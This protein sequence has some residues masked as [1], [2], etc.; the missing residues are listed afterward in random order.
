MP[1]GGKI[2]L[3][4]R[5]IWLERY[6]QGKPIASIAKEE[7]RTERTVID[8]L[9]RARRERQHQQVQ[10]DLLR[11]SYRDHY[12]HLLLLTERLAERC[13]TPHRDG[14]F[15]AV[16]MKERLLYQGLQSHTRGS[17]IWGE[18]KRWEEGVRT[19]AAESDRLEGEADKLVVQEIGESPEVVAKGVAQSLRHSVSMAG[20]GLDPEAVEYV[21]DNSEATYQLRWG[22]FVLAD[23]V[24]DQGRLAE[25]VEKHRGLMNRLFTSQA[26]E[27]LQSRWRE[28][29]EARDALQEQLTILQLRKLL[30]GQCDLCPAGDTGARR[31]P[32]RRRDE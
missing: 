10:A 3:D 21:E 5:R 18:V 4:Q 28:W 17:E 14:L 23:G 27:R 2:A 24:P 15:V 7:G 25:I 26:S 9:E 29:A 12:Q 20:Q 19:L 6:E 8:H 32:R 1:K 30:P 16:E 22:N 11:E 13:Q 31:P